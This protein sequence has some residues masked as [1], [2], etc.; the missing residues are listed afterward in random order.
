[1]KFENL[2]SSTVSTDSA[3]VMARDSCAGAARVQPVACL[4][5]LKNNF[6]FKYIL[7]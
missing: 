3:V 5:K 2:Y 6:Q 4:Y 1:M 7:M